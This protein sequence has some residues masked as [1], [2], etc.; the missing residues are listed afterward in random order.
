MSNVSRRGAIALIAGIASTAIGAARARAQ[1][2]T[3]QPGATDVLI[4][5]DVQNDFLPGGSLAVPHGDAVIAPINAL[6]GRFA[7]VVMT[8][9]WHTPHHIS[10]AS[11]HPGHAPF[12]TIKLADGSTQVLWPDHCVQGSHGAAIAD[13]LHIPAAELIVRKGFHQDVDSY[14][15]FMEADRKTRTGL[16]GYLTERGFTRVFVAGLATDFCVGWTA[17]DARR[18]GFQTFMI[19]DASRGID[20]GGSMAVAM[21]DMASAGVRAY[22][23]GRLRV[24]GATPLSDEQLDAMITAGVAALGLAVE[25]EWMPTIRANLAVS[26]RH[27]NNITEFAMADDAEPAPVFEA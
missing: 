3:I 27:A 26:L 19:E 20:T 9:D 2:M 24:T 11:S 23:H 5:V 22:Q 1:P 7:H 6:A 13:A 18:A 12:D 14:S 4:V 16:A 10:F 17:I 21:K 8:Q 25:P 15:A